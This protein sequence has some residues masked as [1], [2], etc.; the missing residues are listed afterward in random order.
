MNDNTI[1]RDKFKSIVN[2]L[3]NNISIPVI[4]EELGLKTID[5]L[6]IQSIYFP[7]KFDSQGQLSSFQSLFNEEPLNIIDENNS[8]KSR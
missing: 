6:K 1:S 5:V 4:A 3:E 8:T 7:N 2:M